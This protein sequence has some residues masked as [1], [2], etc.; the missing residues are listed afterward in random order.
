ARGVVIADDIEDISK[1]RPCPG[2]GPWGGELVQ[3]IEVVHH[4][5][6]SE[7]V[8][9][10]EQAVHLVRPHVAP[11]LW[12]ESVTGDEALDVLNG[13]VVID[14]AGWRWRQRGAL[15]RRRARM[16]FGGVAEV[17]RGLRAR[18]MGVSVRRKQG[19]PL[20]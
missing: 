19:R 18:P 3:P 10:F 17:L 12:W 16:L 8:R 2:C 5:D 20:N 7:H 9:V 13:E 1:R 4:G 11:C 15:L 6:G 14:E